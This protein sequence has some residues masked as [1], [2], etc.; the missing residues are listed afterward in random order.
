MKRPNLTILLSLLLCALGCAWASPQKDAKAG[1]L[2]G[3]WDCIAHG[4]V[5]GDVAFTLMLQQDHETLTGSVKT[6]DGDLPI[7]TGSYKDGALDIVMDSPDAKYTIKGKLDGG[8]LSGQWTKEGDDGQGGAWE[9][10][11]SAAP[12]A[13]AP[14]KP[15]Q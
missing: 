4:S 14:S 12:A 10:K 1:A 8:Q 13:N 11:R 15:A 2:A 9:G 7:T 6:A 3:S 5:Q